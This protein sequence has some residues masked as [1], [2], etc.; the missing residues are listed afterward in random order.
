MYLF[1]EKGVRGGYSA[2]TK[3]LATA[4]NKYV[5]GYDES[6]PSSYICYL[7]ANNL[8]GWSMSQP[9]PHSDFRWEDTETYAFS[10]KDSSRGYVYEV[11]IEYP[12]NLWST[13][14]D[15]PLAPHHVNITYDML[16]DYSNELVKPN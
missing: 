8:Y 1:F 14:S 11:D 13:H 12:N 6:K 3:R 9:L 7:D 10:L 16:C 2:I 15:F 5:E 4:N